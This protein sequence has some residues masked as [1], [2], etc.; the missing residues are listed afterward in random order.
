MYC[1]FYILNEIVFLELRCIWSLSYNK[2]SYNTPVI[3]EQ[4]NVINFEKLFKKTQN[5]EIGFR[6]TRLL[7]DYSTMAILQ[8]SAVFQLQLLQHYIAIASGW[9]LVTF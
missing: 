3:G 2:C 9:K 8:F 5:Q 7:H 4:I 6:M 1:T